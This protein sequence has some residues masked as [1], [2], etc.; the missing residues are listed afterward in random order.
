MTTA[1]RPAGSP[2]NQKTARLITGRSLFRV[3]VTC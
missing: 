3:A 2:P 1:G